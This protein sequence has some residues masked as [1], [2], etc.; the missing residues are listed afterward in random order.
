MSKQRTALITGASR[1]LGLAVAKVLAASGIRLLLTGRSLEGLKLCANDLEGK[2]EYELFP[3]DLMDANF[4]KKL[5]DDFRERNIK[6]DII[7]HSLGGKVQGDKQPLSPEILDESI[8]FNLGVA[9]QI[10]SHCLPDMLASGNGCIVHVSSDASLTGD[11]APGY[12]AAKAAIN[13]YVKSCARFYAKHKI[14][15]CAVLPGIFEHEGSVWSQKKV[16]DPQH[17]YKK[18]DATALGRFPHSSEIAQ[19]VGE[20][21]NGQ[22][23]VYA[24][25]L[26]ELSAG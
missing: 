1:G 19:V 24:G 21:V 25:S 20:I 5:L 8:R 9:T 3:G 26:I 17:Y 12:V 2:V 18:L 11:A 7:I 10:N 4:L 22:N 6:P 14:L 23:M 16:S 13:A 15:I